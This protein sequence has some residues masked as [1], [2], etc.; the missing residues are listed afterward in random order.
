[1]RLHVQANASVPAWG[2]PPASAAPPGAAAAASPVAS[3]AA[4]AA[5][6]D[7]PCALAFLSGLP[8]AY[9]PTS[10]GSTAPPQ[11]PQ[12][13]LG[14]DAAAASASTAPATKDSSL[15]QAYVHPN[16]QQTLPFVPSQHNEAWLACFEFMGWE[17]QQRS[18]SSAAVSAAAVAATTQRSNVLQ[19]PTAEMPTSCNSSGNCSEASCGASRALEDT[20]SS[21]SCSSAVALLGTANPTAPTQ[22]WQCSWPDDALNHSMCLSNSLSLSSSLIEPACLSDSFSTVA[23]AASTGRSSQGSVGKNPDGTCSAVQVLQSAA[24]TT[25]VAPLCGKDVEEVPSPEGLERHADV[26][27]ATTADESPPT[28]VSSVPRLTIWPSAE[29][30]QHMQQQQHA[31]QQQLRGQHL[32]CPIESQLTSAFALPEQQQQQQRQQQERNLF[33]RELASKQ[34][35]L[36]HHLIPANQQQSQLL[37]PSAEHLVPQQEQEQ[38]QQQ[39]LDNALMLGQHM[40]REQSNSC[41]LQQEANGA[42]QQQQH[43]GCLCKAREE[44]AKHVS[45]ATAAKRVSALLPRLPPCLPI[46]TPG[47]DRSCDRSLTSLLI[48]LPLNL[49]FG[50]ILKFGSGEPGSA[51][52]SAAFAT[53]G[54]S[55]SLGVKKSYYIFSPTLHP[56]AHT[57]FS[58]AG[59]I[60]DTFAASLQMELAIIYVPCCLV[61]LV[62]AAFNTLGQQLLPQLHEPLKLRCWGLQER[63]APG[64]FG[65]KVLTV[66]CSVEGV[67]SNPVTVTFHYSGGSHI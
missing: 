54:S 60:C 5:A 6:V 67:S 50:R 49:P 39:Q 46:L 65:G 32:V 2:S 35:H 16:Q 20:P 29:Q 21:P 11:T 1:M 18:S 3:T 26:P 23:S 7:S 56:A 14:F 47:M 17:Q 66:S 42:D 4:A 36:K 8:H 48:T 30:Q 24:P 44:P 51:A 45:V 27:A 37:Q 10:Q 55:Q 64:R 59:G 22:T 57:L 38:L 28:A 9:S 58:H 52:S 31:Q 15:K 40:Q 25:G 33:Y 12:G 34:K 62:A 53:N 43:Q 61:P 19:L 13:E 41:C 63:N